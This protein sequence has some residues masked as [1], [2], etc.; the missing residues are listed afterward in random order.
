[1]APKGCA[2]LDL[3]ATWS[4]MRA[5]GVRRVGMKTRSIKRFLFLLLVFVLAPAVAGAA[6]IAAR[7]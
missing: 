4:V 3:V 6:A 1:M 5:P 2:S 7:A